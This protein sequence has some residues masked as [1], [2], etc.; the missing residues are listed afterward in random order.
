MKKILVVDDEKEIR[1]LI[2]EG[3]EKNKYT[4]LT[5][6]SGQEA[7]ALCKIHKPDLV[8]LDIAMPLM[9]GY[10]VCAALKQDVQTQTIPVI[11]LTGKDLD[12]HG[13]LERSQDLGASGYVNKPST[14]RD[15]LEKIKEIL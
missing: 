2:K 3:L 14:L 11:F 8:L 7:L 4:A 13:I 6:S 15:L 1:E 9:D 10:Q 5:A 12:P